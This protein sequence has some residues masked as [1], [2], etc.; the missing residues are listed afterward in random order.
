[1][2]TQISHCGKS[3]LFFIHTTITSYYSVVFI[4]SRTLKI[5]VLQMLVILFPICRSLKCNLTGYTRH[6]Y[7]WYPYILVRYLAGCAHSC[8]AVVKGCVGR[9]VSPVC[10]LYD[11]QF[12]FIS[13]ENSN[14]N[15]PCVW[16]NTLIKLL[17]AK[18]AALQF[19]DRTVKI[20]LHIQFLP[21]SLYW[22]Y[23]WSMCLGKTCQSQ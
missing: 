7:W 15:S 8:G 11:Y 1:M 4:T 19:C 6:L 16:R 14:S 10:S 21:G 18:K 3:P 5:I 13:Q 12:D 9:I 22:L 2:Q 20:C 23:I 17:H